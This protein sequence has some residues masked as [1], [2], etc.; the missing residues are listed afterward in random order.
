MC[1]WTRE[2]IAPY[3]PV[4]CY[5]CA[6]PMLYSLPRLTHAARR[7][8]HR[9]F[10]VAADLAQTPERAN[11]EAIVIMAEAGEI[12]VALPDAAAVAETEPKRP[13]VG[14]T[15]P[16]ELKG[17]IETSLVELGEVEACGPYVFFGVLCA[18]AVHG[19]R[20]ATHASRGAGRSTG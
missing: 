5:A 15:M 12:A 13:R 19:G 2:E 14:G 9:D 6:V 4:A 18:R 16:L 3:Y 17:K 11:S 10:L 8:L 20:R 1:C 7:P